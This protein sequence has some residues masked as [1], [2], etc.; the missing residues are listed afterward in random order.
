MSRFEASMYSYG[1]SIQDKLKEQL[2]ASIQRQSILEGNMILLCNI[3]ETLDKTVRQAGFDWSPQI[4]E[5]TK[6][7]KASLE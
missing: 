4:S 1:S 2:D 5:T 3:V 6:K 7:I